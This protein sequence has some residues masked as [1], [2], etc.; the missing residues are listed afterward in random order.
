MEKVI[1]IEGLDKSYDRFAL[2]NVALSLPRGYIMGLIG[3]NGA[4]KTTLIKLILNLVRRDRGTIR[5]FGKTAEQ[6]EAGAKGRIG[7]V[8]DTPRFYD[9]LTLRQLKAI[10]APFY[11][12]WDEGLFERLTARFGLPLTQKIR[13]LSRGMRMKFA[14]ALALSHHAELL[15]MDEPT[16]GLDPVFRR[17]LLE[18]LQE[19]LQ[20]ERKSVLFSTQITSDLERIADYVTYIH[21]GQVVFSGSREEIRENWALVKGG[22]ELLAG[23]HRSLFI[24]V[25]EGARGV[26]ALTANAREAQRRFRDG[27]VIEKASLEDIMV[28]LAEARKG[29]TTN[30]SEH[31]E[32]PTASGAENGHA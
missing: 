6:D 10:V 8:Q 28:L 18:H 19:L 16:T 23:N 5:I 21:G 26:T 17:E 3:P 13:T 2:R 24:A 22:G 30:R 7:F 4:G 11:R 15:I 9:P 29:A 25:R 1:E 31:S 32:K 12:D 27:V 20:D 14:L